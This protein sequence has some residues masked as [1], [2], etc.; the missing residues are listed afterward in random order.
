[1]RNSLLVVAFGLSLGT[2]THAD[3]LRVPQDFPTIQGAVDAAVPFDVVL[4]SSST[5]AG[6]VLIDGLTD[7]ELRGKG[8]VIIEAAGGPAS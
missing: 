6:S 7:V 1:M 3:T 8:K 2:V 5:Y 4:V